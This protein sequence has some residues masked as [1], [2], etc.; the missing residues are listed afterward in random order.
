[1]RIML[2]LLFMAALLPA[3]LGFAAE[4]ATDPA[5]NDAEIR[6]RLVGVWEDDYQG[7]R[8]M[9]IREDGTATMVVQLSGWKSVLYASRLEFWMVWSVQDGRLKKQTTG[10]K[11]SGK[12]NAILKMMGNSVTE[13][14][15]EVTADRLV[16]LDQNGK[17]RYEW[18]R[19]KPALAPNPEGGARRSARADSRLNN[20]S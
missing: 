5:S 18:R 6:Q 19:V 16:L 7:R 20:S 3:R 14:I 9:T 12:V 4:P 10:G 13:K 2:S 17:R 1:M 15:L 11:P 8:T